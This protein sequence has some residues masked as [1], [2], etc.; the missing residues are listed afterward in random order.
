M[1]TVAHL[2][3]TLRAL[4]GSFADTLARQTGFIQQQRKISGSAFLRTL[5]FALL[6][7][8]TRPGEFSHEGRKILRPLGIL[9]QLERRR[10]CPATYQLLLDPRDQSF[11]QGYASLTRARNELLMDQPVSAVYSSKPVDVALPFG[12]QGHSAGLL[13]MRQPSFRCGSTCRFSRASGW[14]RRESV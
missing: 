4:V 5:T 8:A 6:T 14:S 10:K 1:A 3:D 7:S 12:K 11:G 9:Q 2:A 13:L